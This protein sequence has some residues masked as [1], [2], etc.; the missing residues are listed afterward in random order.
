MTVSADP[1]S[2][3]DT[4]VQSI[5]IA[6]SSV[7][8]R[9]AAPFEQTFHDTRGGVSIEYVTGEQVTSRLNEVLGPTGWSFVVVE[10][11]I[12][13][14]ADEIWCLGEL[15]IYDDDNPLRV[16]KRVQFGSQKLKRPRYNQ[17]YPDQARPPL[18]IGFDL[19]GA[20]TDCLK[21]CASLIGVGL[22]LSRKE[23]QPRPRPAA[24]SNGQPQA[25]QQEHVTYGSGQ[26]PKCSECGAEL[27]V[28]NFRDGTSWSAVQ[29][30]D[31]GQKKHARVLCMRHYREANDAKR[32]QEASV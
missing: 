12:H 8:E 18:D 6:Q 32:A 11:G 13:I 10:H 27:T 1:R 5:A 23:E 19:K 25:T 21:K 15:T 7:Y 3:S 26:V 16:T 20:A 4:A 14:E 30:A 9:L 17:Q 2:S 28:T 29:L 31:A 24:P 22:Y